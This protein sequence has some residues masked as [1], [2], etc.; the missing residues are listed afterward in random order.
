MEATHQQ[1]VGCVF[2]VEAAAQRIDEFAMKVR[3]E[4]AVVTAKNAR[5]ATFVKFGA[6]DARLIA[7]ACRA[8]QGT[9][10][11]LLR[12][13]FA[14]SVKERAPQARDGV[15]VS[16]R[17][18]AQSAD[19]AAAAAD[20]TVLLAPE[21]AALLAGSD[22]GF[23]VREV[24][25]PGG[26]MALA[27]SLGAAAADTGHAALDVR[28]SAVPPLPVDE[29]ALDQARAARADAL[30]RAQVDLESRHEA[31]LGQIGRAAERLESMAAQV[32]ALTQLI[33]RSQ[34]AAGALEERLARSE[35]D[36]RLVLARCDDI[37]AL[38]DKVD[39]LLGR[40]DD[41]DGKIV[42]IES[43]RKVVE[44]VQA[45]A[46]GITHMLDDIHLNLE[47]LG[48]QR[49]VV[50]D[51]GEK[52]A[53]LEFTVQEAHN[54]LRALQRERELAERIEQGIKALRARSGKAG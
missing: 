22:L 51:V 44:E 28:A 25:L 32:A 33:E 45:R 38:R 17:C 27:C 39:G 18:I 42:A 11:S 7:L 15:R 21:F 52:L 24:P 54:T 19:L 23:Q 10:G 29:D 30:Q 34:Q 49:A 4:R 31:M 47:M 6:S 13:G 43:R 3:R 53:R 2:S 35:H 12:F 20:G 26:R 8:A 9:A 46:E 50:D 40:L 37:A 36:H 16:A 5:Q 1:I 48:E 41:T 14:C